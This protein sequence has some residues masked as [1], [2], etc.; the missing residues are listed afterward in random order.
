M[1]RSP[2]TAALRATVASHTA[3]ALGAT[4]AHLGRAVVAN[5]AVAVGIGTPTQVCGFLSVGPR[6]RGHAYSAADMTF[7]E[8]VAAHYLSVLEA[9]H[10]RNAQ[11]AAT[12]AELRA[13]RAQINPHFLFNA[14]TLLAERVRAQPGA[15][16]LVL[17]LAEIFRFA[18]ESTQHDTV[19]LRAELAAIEAYLQIEGERFGHLLRWTID[20][21]DD[22]RDTPIPPM[23]LQ[24][25]VENA[26]RHGLAATPNGGTVRVI[27]SHTGASVLLTVAD[28]GA[29]FTPGFTQERVGLSNVRARV[30]HAGGKWHLHAAPGAGTMITMEVGVQ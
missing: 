28:D 20:V 14:L 9:S 30:E 22:L 2:D 4:W 26:I 16:R 17:N 12:V 1:A 21:P 27:A 19:P 3:E 18:L 13:L 10:A 11:H 5:S 23:V 29:G 24:P 8:A 7:V 6:R 25:L 15:E